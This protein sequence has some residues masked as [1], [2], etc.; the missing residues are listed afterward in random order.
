MRAVTVPG[1]VML[2]NYSN[3]TPEVPLTAKGKTLHDKDQTSLPGIP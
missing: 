1:Q 3:P 2:N